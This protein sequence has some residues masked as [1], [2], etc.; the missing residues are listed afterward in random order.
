MGQT[1][2]TSHRC[3]SLVDREGSGR[4]VQC[5]IELMERIEP[6]VIDAFASL[7]GRSALFDVA[8]FGITDMCFEAVAYDDEVV[9]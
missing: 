3:A 5:V 6:G 4:F 9:R 2:L 7:L 1:A 8:Q